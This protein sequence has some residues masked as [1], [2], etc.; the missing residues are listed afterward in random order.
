MSDLKP[1]TGAR[2]LLELV[3]EADDRTSAT[4]RAVIATPS[5][6][7]ESTATLSD[8]G[9]VTLPAMGA[10][11]NLEGALAMF[12]KLVARG[13]TKR[14]IDGMPVWPQRVMRWRPG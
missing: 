1:Q 14:R 8:D 9:E 2:F 13:A 6:E 7:M 3:S 10:P 4:Y 5:D 12:A 11:K